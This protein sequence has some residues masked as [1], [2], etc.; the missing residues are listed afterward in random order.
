M[1]GL[2]CSTTRVQPLFSTPLDAELISGRLQC[3]ISKV[4]VVC[5]PLP[6]SFYSSASFFPKL[7]SDIYFPPAPLLI[8]LTPF[9]PLLF[10]LIM[11]LIEGCTSSFFF[12]CEQAAA[13]CIIPSRRLLHCFLLLHYCFNIFPLWVRARITV[14]IIFIPWLVPSW[15]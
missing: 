9:R 8:V 4:I 1:L 5:I 12:F 14:I 13:A 7:L 10:F 3:V 2:V 6:R 11:P 15:R